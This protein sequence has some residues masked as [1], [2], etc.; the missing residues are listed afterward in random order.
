MSALEHPLVARYLRD[1]DV[2]LDRLPPDAAAELAEQIRAHLE[3]AL[4]PDAD[5]Q[6]VAAALAAL[7]PASLVAEAARPEIGAGRSATPREPLKRRIARSARKVPIAGWLAI[8]ALCIAIGLPAGAVIYWNV[9]PSLQ[10]DG[11][12]TWWGPAAHEVDTQAAGATQ[13]TVQIL[14]GQIQGFE[15]TISNPSDMTQV[16]VSSADNI[17]PGAPVPPRIAVST[18][19]KLEQF[20]DADSVKYRIGGPIPPHSYRWVRV[21][22]RSYYCYLNGVGSSQG[23]SDLLLRVRV[24]GIT[25]TE[26]IQLPMEFAVGVFA[27][28][29][30]PAS[31]GNQAVPHP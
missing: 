3:E 8:A 11:E 22:W 5:D 30:H 19:G 16:I 4:P 21:L 24:G 10:F 14:P 9:Q 29:P 28:G 12:S 23:T 6:A 18:T 2:A 7:G 25:R 15:I 27:S 17:S 1:L 31:C 20:G 26:D 13:E